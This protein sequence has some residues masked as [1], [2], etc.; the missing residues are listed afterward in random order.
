MRRTV[1]ESFTVAVVAMLCAGFAT[2]AGTDAKGTLDYKAR[3]TT[4]K[5]AYLVTG[6]DAV[7]KQP[8]R[9][10]ILSATDLGAKIAACKTMSC[11][12]NDLNEGLSV[13]FEGGA[14]MNYWLV[15]NGQKVQYSGTEPMPSLA[16]KV[17]DGKQLSGTLKFDKSGAGGPK[18]D[19]EFDAT[20]AK[21]LTAP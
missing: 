12:D 11:T 20:L 18:V 17:N 13:N 1:P 2:A 15:Q 8:I 16:A 7:S 6:P 4:V 10:L 21:A 19:V 5:Y 14:R 9:R 3:I